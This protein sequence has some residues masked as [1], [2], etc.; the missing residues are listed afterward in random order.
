LSFGSS[1]LDIQSTL[2]TLKTG[3]VRG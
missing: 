2:K 3:F 1:H